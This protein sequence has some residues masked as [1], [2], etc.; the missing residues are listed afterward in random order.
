ML[1]DEIGEH[2]YHLC[3]GN[4]KWSKP[5]FELKEKYSMDLEPEK[6]IPAK[7]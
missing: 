3:I 6:F 7:K 5:I 1:P 4:T 2:L